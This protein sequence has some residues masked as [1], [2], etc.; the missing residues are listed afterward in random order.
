[1]HRHDQVIN[2]TKIHSQKWR[3]MNSSSK[4]IHSICEKL[5]WTTKN[6]RTFDHLFENILDFTSYSAT[7]TDSLYI[8]KSFWEQNKNIFQLWCVRDNI[9]MC[10]ATLYTLKLSYILWQSTCASTTTIFH[11]ISFVWFS[12]F[13]AQLYITMKSAFVMVA[14]N[15]LCIYIVPL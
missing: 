5:V 13:Y 3:I 15:V 9:C 14:L 2:F 8:C 10:I 1:M 7:L 6:K 11:C 4:N 12:Y